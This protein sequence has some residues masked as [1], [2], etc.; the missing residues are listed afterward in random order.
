MV[1]QLHIDFSLEHKSYVVDLLSMLASRTKD[2]SEQKI[3]EAQLFQLLAESAVDQFTEYESDKELNLLIAQYPII[4]HLLEKY[5]SLFCSSL[6]GVDPIVTL[7]DILVLAPQL[8][9]RYYSI[10]SSSLTSPSKISITVAALHIRNEIN[11]SIRGVCSNY[12]ADVKPDT[13]IIASVVE[14]N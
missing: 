4:V 11:T 14:S 8:K 6:E 2:L 1:L 9:H 13:Y 12:L 7:A 10:L 5:Q 3:Q